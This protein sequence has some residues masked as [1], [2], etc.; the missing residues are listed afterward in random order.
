MGMANE[1]AGR[2]VS[3]LFMIYGPF[4]EGRFYRPYPTQA[5]ANDDYAGEVTKQFQRRNGNPR[6]VFVHGFLEAADAVRRWRPTQWA[7]WRTILATADHS[8]SSRWRLLDVIRIGQAGSSSGI[9]RQEPTRQGGAT[10]CS[11]HDEFPV[12]DYWLGVDWV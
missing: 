9:A 6:D 3:K 1:V 11:G 7:S 12:M 8:A 10:E 2:I 4:R 5:I